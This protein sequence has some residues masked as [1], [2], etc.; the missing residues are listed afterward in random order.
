MIRRIFELAA[1][2]VVLCLAIAMIAIAPTYEQLE[3][4]P[5]ESRFPTMN[6]TYPSRR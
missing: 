6:A 3:R 2:L 5:D 4:Q 1:A